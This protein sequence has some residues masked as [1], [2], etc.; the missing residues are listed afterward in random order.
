MYT[1][2][3]YPNAMPVPLGCYRITSA[4][5]ELCKYTIGW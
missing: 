2:L 3:G 4:L 5:R 1:L